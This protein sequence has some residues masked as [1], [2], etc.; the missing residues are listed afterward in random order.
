MYKFPYSK[1][2]FSQL[3]QD[4]RKEVIDAA[5]LNINERQA[6]KKAIKNMKRKEKASKKASDSDMLVSTN[7]PEN[8]PYNN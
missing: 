3:S 7:Q 5:N 6:E 1:P 8:S 2:L 4:K